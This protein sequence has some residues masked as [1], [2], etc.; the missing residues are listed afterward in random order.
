[1][2]QLFSSWS[3]ILALS[4]ITAVSIAAI[5]ATC[6]LRAEADGLYYNVGDRKIPL[7][8]QTDSIAVSMGK[9]RGAED[10]KRLMSLLQQDFGAGTRG[11][12]KSATKV[13]LLSSRYAILTAIKDPLGG[14]K[15]KQKAE[16]KPYIESTL[17]VLKIP[18]TTSMLVLPNETIVKFNPGISSADRVAIL[19]RN[20]FDPNSATELQFARGFYLVKSTARGLDVLTASNQLGKTSGVRSSMPN[21]I[22]VQPTTDRPSF[23]IRKLGNPN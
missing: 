14:V 9:N 20:Q 3:L 10:G 6:N 13:Q 1:V 15:L 11:E 4:I 16:T 23:G 7:V 17:P 18:G 5:G 8:V 12:A 2:K 21:F 19:T 22:Q